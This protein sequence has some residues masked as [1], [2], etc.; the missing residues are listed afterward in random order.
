[1]RKNIMIGL[2]VFG[3]LAFAHEGH[4]QVPGTEQGLYGGTVAGNKE[5]FME[6]VNESGIIKIYPM[7]HEKK[8]IDAQGLKLVITATSPKKA[9]LPVT[10]ETGKD[11]VTVKV[12]AKGVHRY[13]LEVAVNGKPDKIKFQVEPQ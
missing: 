11:F 8:P 6:L 9:K 13:S 10:F 3:A 5:V 12:D 7:T 4:D 1:M 2:L